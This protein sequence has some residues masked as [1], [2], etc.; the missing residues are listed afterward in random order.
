MEV[1]KPT[2]ERARELWMQHGIRRRSTLTSVTPAT[3]RWP[4]LGREATAD[5]RDRLE[6]GL[7]NAAESIS[8]LARG[9][10]R[11]PSRGKPLCARATT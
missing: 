9:D 11:R 8:H 10:D 2:P 6:Q 4:S 5:S 1:S 3:R 7:M